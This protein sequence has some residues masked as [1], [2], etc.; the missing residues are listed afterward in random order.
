ML[1]SRDPLAAR[2]AAAAASSSSSSSRYSVSPSS[3]VALL[4]P[5]DRCIHA[6]L[7]SMEREGDW[8]RALGLLLDMRK[9][10][11]QE[12]QPGGWAVQKDASP[13][14][15]NTYHQ[16]QQRRHRS[17][18]KD[19]HEESGGLL[20][21]LPFFLPSPD[22]AAC[23][24]VLCA[25]VR[26]GAPIWW[27]RAVFDDMQDPTTAAAGASKSQRR[28]L[29]EEVLL[30][31]RNT[32]SYNAMMRVYLNNGQPREALWLRQR[33]RYRQEQFRRCFQDTV[34]A[35]ESRLAAA[36]KKPPPPLP[37]PSS[38]SLSSASSSS[39]FTS[40]RAAPLPLPMDD[41]L[42]AALRA[43]GGDMLLTFRADNGTHNLALHA[44]RAA[45]DVDAAVQELEDMFCAAPM[46]ARPVLGSMP[47]S[48]TSTSM[49]PSTPKW[50]KR[51]ETC[52]TLTVHGVEVR[53]T[54][55]Q[56]LHHLRL[57]RI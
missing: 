9:Q 42:N 47:S 51:T 37:P 43:A 38:L 18:R 8:T 53:A 26:G 2:P 39:S 57:R 40:A 23:N 20:H 7:R 13:A 34:L 35:V 15:H 22:T 30:P 16:Q 6:V 5:D 3:S 10:Q 50:T 17:A 28:G 33:L 32:R 25:C 1:R 21:H 19:D 55:D 12:H 29:G 31:M 46:E 54:L 14:P 48:S 52:V 24:L 4:R 36:G 11:Q 45:G 41:E 44:A 56:Q 49:T 27:A